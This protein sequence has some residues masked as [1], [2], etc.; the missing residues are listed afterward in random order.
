MVMVYQVIANKLLPLPRV[1]FT[2]TGTVLNLNYEISPG[3]VELKIFANDWGQY[4]LTGTS[5]FRLVI[6]P[7]NAASVPGF[8]WDNYEEI[9]KKY[10]YKETI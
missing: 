1:L 10:A 6:I 7:A 9:V 8:S 3:L 5:L 4:L 2:G